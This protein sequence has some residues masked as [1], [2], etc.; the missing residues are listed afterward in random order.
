ML[1]SATC[2]CS[3]E[4]KIAALRLVAVQ[5]QP[6]RGLGGGSR[7][8]F[9]LE[10][11]R[12]QFLCCCC[13]QTVSNTSGPGHNCAVL[14]HALQTNINVP[15]SSRQLAFLMLMRVDATGT[16]LYRRA[17]RCGVA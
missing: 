10:A 3:V 16:Q 9:F 12:A 11:V 4:T 15:S 17:S 1:R 7:L 8:A 14:L 6:C 5:P 13:G 2:L